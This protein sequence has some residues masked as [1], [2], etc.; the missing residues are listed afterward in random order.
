[1]ALG[2]PSEACRWAEE[3]ELGVPD[4]HCHDESHADVCYYPLRLEY[5]PTPASPL[6]S[7]YRLRILRGTRDPE[8]Q[9]TFL[10][11]H[12]TFILDKVAI[13][14]ALALI[15]FRAPRDALTQVDD[16]LWMG[17]ARTSCCIF[18][19]GTAHMDVLEEIGEE[20]TSGYGGAWVWVHSVDDSFAR[21]PRRLRAERGRQVIVM[22]RDDTLC[23]RREKLG[24]K[25]GHELDTT[26]V[27]RGRHGRR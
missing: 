25:V 10:P 6:P 26:T 19:H 14:G 23:V 4:D 11:P 15:V 17:L 12:S 1:M 18:M 22:Q 2:M 8:L 9:A 7:R 13:A 21:G 16:G 20:Y 3:N 24:W 27:P 5:D